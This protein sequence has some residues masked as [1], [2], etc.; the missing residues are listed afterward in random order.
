MGYTIE[1]QDVE[2]LS[3]D[4]Q[5]AILESLV[6]ALAADRKTSPAE[7][8]EL[9]AQLNAVPWTMQPPQVIEHLLE[10]RTRV[11]ALPPAE[12]AALIDRIAERL[13]APALREKLFHAMASIMAADHQMS[14][15]ERAVL[16]RYTKAFGLTVEQ[17]EAIK[18]DVKS[19]SPAPPSA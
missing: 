7:T 16:A 6:L 1:K 3:D 5:V 17:I 14:V 12:A 19:R 9:E 4:Q 18:A 11:L 10:V 15:D 8:G 13:P 2:G